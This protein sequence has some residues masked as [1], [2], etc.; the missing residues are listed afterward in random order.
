MGENELTEVDKETSLA[1]LAV[2]PPLIKQEDW[3]GYEN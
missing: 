2:C 1:G 3:T